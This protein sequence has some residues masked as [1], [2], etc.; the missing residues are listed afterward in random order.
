MKL[1][2]LFV[3]KNYPNQLVLTDIKALERFKS[4]IFGEYDIL[5]MT[6]NYTKGHKAGNQLKPCQKLLMLEYIF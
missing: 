3:R 1:N 2:Y 4:S 6:I 5:Q